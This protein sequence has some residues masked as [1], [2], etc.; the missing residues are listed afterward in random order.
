MLAM[1]LIHL[2]PILYEVL[3]INKCKCMKYVTQTYAWKSP[4][5]CYNFF[6]FSNQF[7]F[8]FYE[9]KLIVPR[10]FV[11]LFSCKHIMYF[12]EI[13]PFYF[14]SLTSVS[15][16]LLF[17]SFKW[18]SWCCFQTYMYVTI[19]FK[20]KIVLHIQLEIDISNFS[21]RFCSLWAHF[22]YA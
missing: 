1:K 3:Y 2:P 22:P 6:A 12:D 5:L 16:P 7:L 8:Y 10:G 20:R 4:R 21:F 18:V 14:C 9:H 19:Y 13:N 17:N 15:S 11:V